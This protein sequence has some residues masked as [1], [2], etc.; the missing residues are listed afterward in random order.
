MQGNSVATARR[1]RPG[2]HILRPVAKVLNRIYKYFIWLFLVLIV[3]LTFIVLL[4]IFLRWCGKG[5]IWADEMS[6][7]LIIWM[8]F[9]AMALG[10]EINIHVEI[11]LFFKL[12][13]KKFQKFWMA[14]NQIITMA[15]GGFIAYYGVLLINI[16][17]KGK[18]EIVRDLPKSVFYLSIPLGGF[19]IVYFA[20]MHLLHREDLMPSAVPGLYPGSKE[21]VD[22]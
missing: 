21:G 6:R 9:V 20:L 18:L 1:E 7:M 2:D 8:A 5:I 12:L 17:A 10:V 4:D 19:F 22:L 15:I 16:A 13:P 3:A 14:V 11:T